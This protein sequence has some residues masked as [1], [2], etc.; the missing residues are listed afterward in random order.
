MCSD[1]RTVEMIVDI[2]VGTMDLVNVTA[3]VAP[4]LTWSG[5]ADWPN[6]HPITSRLPGER[7][8]LYLLRGKAILHEMENGGGGGDAFCSS[9]APLT[10][11]DFLERM[12]HPSASDFVKSIKRSGPPSS[13]PCRGFKTCGTSRF[14]SVKRLHCHWVD[15]DWG[16]D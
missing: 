10:W 9:T 6:S 3:D 2:V 5:W 12:R 16:S 13:V 11:H 1:S 7:F 4:G 15:G 8:D 14:D